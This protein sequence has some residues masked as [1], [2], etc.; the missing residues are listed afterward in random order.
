VS[1]LKDGDIRS[2]S[3]EPDA[4]GVD[5]VQPEAL[6]GGLPEEN[7][8]A[9]HSVLEG[10]AGAFRDVVIMNAAAGLTV[11]RRAGDLVEAAR[12]ARDSLD[13]GRALAALERLVNVSNS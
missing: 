10:E 8:R 13:S 7:A 3:V 11:A 5:I 1:E 4:F 2:F 6:L 12:I 9:L